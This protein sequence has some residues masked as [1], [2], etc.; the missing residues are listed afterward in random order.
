MKCPKC[1]YTSF[2]YLDECKKCGKDLTEHK[3]K[4]NIRSLMFP[5]AGGVAGVA[6][7]AV[8]GE[9]EEFGFD[10][11]EEGETAEASSE[12]ATEITEDDTFD[13][14]DDDDSFSFDEDETL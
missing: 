4:Y 9:S 12:P 14:G 7:A 10:F 1:S 13:F 5:A 8:T 3:E 2:D 6:T 11:M